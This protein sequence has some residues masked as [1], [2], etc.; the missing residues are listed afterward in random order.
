MSRNSTCEDDEDGTG[1]FAS[2][3]CFMHELDPS[4]MG[5]PI[6]PQQR[7]DV[8]RWRKSERE[9]LVAARFAMSA[10]ERL[11]HAACIAKRSRRF[12]K[13][14]ARHHSQRLLASSR[15]AGP[16]ALDDGSL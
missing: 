8:A 12:P 14:R 3:P 16:E 13:H 7:R 6:D 15:R 2:P 11:E 4:Y 10:D 5:M 1:Q 9:C